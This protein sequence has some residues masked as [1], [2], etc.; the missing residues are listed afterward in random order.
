MQIGAALKLRHAVFSSGSL[1]QWQPACRKRVAVSFRRCTVWFGIGTSCD[2]TTR[3]WNR[4]VSKRGAFYSAVAVCCWIM[5]DLESSWSP[6][7]VLWRHIHTQ[8]WEYITHPLAPGVQKLDWEMCLAFDWRKMNWRAKSIWAN[9]KF[10]VDF[11]LF[12]FPLNAF[13][14]HAGFQI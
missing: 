14:L 7:I 3:L 2:A 4:T 13:F 8:I 10:F 1:A 12:D 6:L 5:H 9:R 11:S